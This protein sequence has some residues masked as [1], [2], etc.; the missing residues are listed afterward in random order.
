MRSLLK[1]F[2]RKGK[3]SSF[4]KN[5]I[6]P[7]KSEGCSS[8]KLILMST[9][10]KYNNNKATVCSNNKCITLYGDTAK[11]LQTIVVVAVGLIAFAAV[12]KAWRL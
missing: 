7:G 2:V 12:A 4:L 11:K 3:V 6:L 8:V 9:K 1:V 5:L 10:S